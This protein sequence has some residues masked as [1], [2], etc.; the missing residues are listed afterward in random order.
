MIFLSLDHYE[1]PTD[2]ADF[3][4][5]SNIILTVVFAL[6]MACMLIG[7]GWKEYC[8]DRMNLFDA[9]VVIVSIIELFLESSNGLSALRCFRLLRLLKLF[10]NW[11]DLRAKVDALFNSLEELT[12]FVGLLF[13]FMFIYAILGVQLFRTRYELDGEVQRPN[14]DNFLWALL[15]V[16]QI[17][18]GENWNEVLVTGIRVAGWGASIYFVTLQVFGSILLDLFLAILLTNLMLSNKTLQEEQT[19]PTFTELMIAALLCRFR[20]EDSDRKRNTDTDQKHDGDEKNYSMFEDD[21]TSVV[22]PYPS[23]SSFPR[24]NSDKK[25]TPTCSAVKHLLEEKSTHIA[26]H[27]P[28]VPIPAD[29]AVTLGKVATSA[30]N[31]CNGSDCHTPR[32]QAFERPAKLKE[33]RPHSRAASHSPS[34]RHGTYQGQSGSPRAWMHAS[35]GSLVASPLASPVPN[36]AKVNES[37]K[38]QS[39]DYKSRSQA[40]SL[41]HNPLPRRS[42][43]KRS[44]HRSQ[45]LKKIGSKRSI[46]QGSFRKKKEKSKSKSTRRSQSAW[47]AFRQISKFVSR[48]KT[49]KLKRSTSKIFAWT[50]RR[51]KSRASWRKGGPNDP[52]SSFYEAK[53]EVLI[54]PTLPAATYTKRGGVTKEMTL[55]GYSFYIFGPEHPLR[56]WI[57]DLVKHEAFGIVVLGLIF[58]SCLLLTLD[59]PKLDPNSK[60]AEVLF[61]ADL[62][63]T[64]LF[65]IEMLLKCIAYSCFS[66]SSTIIPLRG[67]NSELRRSVTSSLAFD[68]NVQ[69]PTMGT[70]MYFYNADDVQE[71]VQC[72]YFSTGWNQIDA[73]VVLISILNL[74]SGSLAFFKAFRAVRSLRALRAVSRSEATKLVVKTIMKTILRLHNILLI[75]LLIFI[76]FAV[77][78]V[79]FFQGRLRLCL[80]DV[81]S[82]LPA[83]NFDECLAAGYRWDNPKRRH[84]DNVGSAMLLLFEVASLEQWPDIMF[85]V[86][87]AT[88]PNQPPERDHNPAA[89][90]FFVSFLLFG[91]FLIVSM[92]VGAVVSVY[93][94]ESD[95]INSV[96]D[97]KKSKNK[98]FDR[99]F[100]DLRRLWLEVWKIMV[101]VRPAYVMVPPQEGGWRTNLFN[102]VQSET[103]EFSI[104]GII[105]VNVLLLAMQYEGADQQYL[106][107]LEILNLTCTC[108][109]FLELVTKVVALGFKQYI[110]SRWNRFD[111]FLVAISVVTLTISSTIN[112]TAIRTF[113][114]LRIFRLLPKWKGLRQIVRTLMFSLPA[115]YNILFLL[116]L[117]IFIYAVMGM[118]LFGKVRHGEYLDSRSNFEDFPHAVIT[119]FGVTTGE[120]WNGLMHDCMVQPPE[121]TEGEDCGSIPLALLFFVTFM[122]FAF[123]S[124]LNLIVAV[125]LKNFESEEGKAGT[126]S[127]GFWGLSPIKPSDI[128]RYSDM[129]SKVFP[130]ERYI[131][132]KDLGRWVVHL[133]FVEPQRYTI[134]VQGKKEEEVRHFP[135]KISRREMS[136]LNIPV[137]DNKVHYLSVLQRIA[138]RKFCQTYASMHKRKSEEAKEKKIA[139]PPPIVRT[140]EKTFFRGFSRDNQTLNLVNSSAMTEYPELSKLKNFR[141]LTNQWFATIKVQR[142]WMARKRSRGEEVRVRLVPEAPAPPHENA[143]L[144]QGCC[145]APEV[146]LSPKQ[147][148][149]TNCSIRRSRLVPMEE[150]EKSDSVLAKD[151]KEKVS[152]EEV[153]KEEEVSNLKRASKA[154]K[155][156]KKDED[157]KEENIKKEVSKEDVSKKEEEVRKNE[158]VSKKEEVRKKEDDSKEDDGMES[159]GKESDAKESDGKEKSDGKESDNKEKSDDKETSDGMKSDSKES[160]VEKNNFTKIEIDGGANDMETDDSKD[161]K[162]KR[163][164][165]QN[166]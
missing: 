74:F 67:S 101:E 136:S 117:T 29:N 76:I 47:G 159:D 71:E 36:L 63:L 131:N 32:R 23:N 148:S 147:E 2:L 42:L 15:T 46:T 38:M 151:V 139:A 41:D 48:S 18:T 43:S 92:F 108:I 55:V 37:K 26:T 91:S 125:V 135:F 144:F 28:G 78:G 7:L 127:A 154:E 22:V 155:I 119:L 95:K 11:P 4:Y 39:K 124:M 126:A 132:V 114:I 163:A 120:G 160:D 104:M 128:E 62:I 152:D 99:D 142:W 134:T 53:K 100:D 10:R 161:D 49:G 97:Q 69:L 116:A 33:N 8:S 24:T 77:I 84:F 162:A 157:S 123:Y 112:P 31:D 5:Y 68:P 34:T 89:S 59:S 87:D 96:D 44:L 30:I 107:V 19:G 137:V 6:E 129:W 158:E 66:S 64:I 75:T 54:N 140:I 57:Y 60:L 121:C 149:R 51:R 52:Y 14:F 165:K 86:I 3:L 90:L 118:S 105:C 156:S 50:T 17:S 72:A 111:A 103:F 93:Q 133:Q 65:T 56:A 88:P 115:L 122:L 98:K 83:L 146:A 35:K 61:I 94:D 153:S 20:V 81:G 113:R 13:L 21:S 150:K 85:E 102:I 27:Q 16:F 1:M 40:M 143:P 73:F 12:Y 109:F 82:Q 9:V 79:Q 45:Q 164:D 110:R 138:L 58:I 145:G 141:F 130:N 70:S 166:S 25:I 106:T 80:D